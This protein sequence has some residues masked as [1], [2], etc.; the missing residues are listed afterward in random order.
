MVDFSNFILLLVAAIVSAHCCYY[1][2]KFVGKRINKICSLWTAPSPHLSW[3]EVPLWAFKLLK[4]IILH[5]PTQKDET[6]W[7]RIQD[8]N[9]GVKF[10]TGPPVSTI[11]AHPIHTS[12]MCLTVWRPQGCC[13]GPSLLASISHDTTNSHENSL[14]IKRKQTRVKPAWK[15]YW[16]KS[17]VSA[18]MCKWVVAL[19]R[20]VTGGFRKTP[21]RQRC[22]L[23]SASENHRKPAVTGSHEHTCVRKGCKFG[24]V[25]PTCG[26]AGLPHSQMSFNTRKYSTEC[27]DFFKRI[28]HLNIGCNW[29]L[30]TQK[31][32]QV[33]CRKIFPR[34]S[35]FSKTCA[36]ALFPWKGNTSRETRMIYKKYKRQSGWGELVCVVV[37]LPC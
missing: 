30:I 27:V 12:N 28:L 36:W 9:R 3:Y 6:T 10:R 32:G 25:R 1:P 15:S 5:L 11:R 2:V 20:P 7:W 14:K 22:R 26:S 16:Q 18:A 21:T 33:Q 4:L 13:I 8:W 34:R 31:G 23:S 29:A 24:Y 35:P 37:S 19:S 17:G